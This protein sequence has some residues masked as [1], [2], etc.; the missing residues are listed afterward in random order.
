MEKDEARFE[1]MQ[2]NL[3]E[4]NTIAIKNLSSKLERLEH[5]FEELLEDFVEHCNEEDD[6]DGKV[7]KGQTVKLSGVGRFKL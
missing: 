7:F 5:N 6:E 2:M 3:N 4:S 1:A